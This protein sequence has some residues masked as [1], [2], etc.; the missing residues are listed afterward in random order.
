[1]LN[2]IIRRILFMVPTVVGI[3]FVVFCL[4]AL[5]PGGIGAA[6]TASGGQQDASKAAILQAYLEDRYG[7][8]DPVL[9]QYGRWLHRI[10]PVKFG[11]RD[12]VTPAGERLQPPKEI[13]EVPLLA[14]GAF[15]LPPAPPPRE[16]PALRGVDGVERQREYRKF[17]NDAL[18]ARSRYLA[19]K[20]EFESALVIYAESTG[21]RDLLDRKGKIML[22]RV[23]SA[24]ADRANGEWPSVA[25][26]HEKMRAAWSA[27][28]AAREDLARAFAE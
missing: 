2:Y 18:T 17:A 7:L 9:V 8:N 20:R 4:L 26:A 27:A 21:Q 6:L 10:S 13:P 1:M 28:V 19:S 11:V 23:E 25:A 24:P 3:T 14:W 16:G 12:Q 5:S 22:D 15:E